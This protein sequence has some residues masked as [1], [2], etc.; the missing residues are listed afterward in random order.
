ME[1]GFQFH[2]ITLLFSSMLVILFRFVVFDID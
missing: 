2:L 1:L